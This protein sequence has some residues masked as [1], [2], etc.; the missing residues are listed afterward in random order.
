[1]YPDTRPWLAA[2]LYEVEGMAW[3]TPQEIRNRY[4]TASFLPGNL[5]IF[6]VR[7]NNHRLEV[8]VAFRTGI[9]TVLWIGT[10]RDYDRRNRVR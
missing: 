8:N 7:G 4:A 3:T 9:V 5:A 1:M 6:N 2:W 10:H